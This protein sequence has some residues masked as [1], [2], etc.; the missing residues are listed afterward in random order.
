M[1]APPPVPAV[2]VTDLAALLAADPGLALI[3]VRETHEYA[4]GHVPGT[5]S[6]PMS[7]LPVRL[8]DVPR[9][10]T[11]YLVCHTGGRS[12]QVAAWLLPQGYDVVNVDGGTAAWI[13]AGHPVE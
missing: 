10:R 5:V 8:Q 2:G 12:G 11:V 4:S 9:D 13:L 1:P 7:V 3:D 6:I